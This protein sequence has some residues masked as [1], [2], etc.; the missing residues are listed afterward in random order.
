MVARY[1]ASAVDARRPMSVLGRPPPLLARRRAPLN[2]V[3]FPCC[4][5][6]Q[7]ADTRSTCSGVDKFRAI[8]ALDSSGDVVV[9]IHTDNRRIQ[10]PRRMQSVPLKIGVAR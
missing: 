5:E 3:P 9:T 10:P 6:V 2:H 8:A 4:G 7:P 1:G